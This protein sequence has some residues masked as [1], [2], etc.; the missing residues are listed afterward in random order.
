VEALL[1]LPLVD[2]VPIKVLFESGIRKSE[3]RALRLA[4]IRPDPHPGVSAFSA[5]RAARIA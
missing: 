2:A 4:D 3:A 5:A 1:A